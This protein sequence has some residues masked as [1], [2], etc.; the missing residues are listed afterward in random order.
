VSGNRQVAPTTEKG[1]A[2]SNIYQTKTTDTS[3]TPAVPAEVPSSLGEIAESTKEGLLAL[4]VGAGMQVMHA[5]MDADVAALA[6]P[7]GKHIAGRAAVRHGSEDGSVT[8]GGRRVP[9]RRP[10]VRAA[11]GT[12]EVA[13]P[14][15]ELFSSTEVLGRMALER[16]LAG[17]STRRYR[18]GLEPVGEKVQTQAAST[19][20]SAV[21]RPL[22]ARWWVCRS[23]HRHRRCRLI[24]HLR[25]GRVRHPASRSWLRL[26]ARRRLRRHR[27][28]WPRPDRRAYA[29][30]DDRPV[31]P[32]PPLATTIDRYVYGMHPG[33]SC[34]PPGAL[35]TP[36]TG[37]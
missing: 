8:L 13:S 14:S 2:V 22:S 1:T 35:A 34:S 21:S 30:R 31:P 27:Q 12:G 36:R 7:K 11:D 33:A 29:T 25:S 20:R 15:Y 24:L 18:H 17:L 28:P 6:G 3:P 26:S 9:V 32:P 19:S 16:M 37:H 23:T 4:A 10:R 5:M